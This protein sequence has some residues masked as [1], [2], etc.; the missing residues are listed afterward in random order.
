MRG[1]IIGYPTANIVP[2]NEVL[3]PQGVYAVR[4]FWKKKIYHGMANLGERP[5]FKRKNPFINIEVNIFDFKRS[6][7]GEDITIEFIK[8]VRK[9][10]KFASIEALKRQL[11]KDE[12]TIKNL[13]FA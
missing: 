12:K 4:I 3:P 13:F 8:K 2:K 11:S 6:I 9:E 7:Y 5:S 10:K 1:A